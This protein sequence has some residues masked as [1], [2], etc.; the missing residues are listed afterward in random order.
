MRLL[1][2]ENIHSDMVLWLRGR[3]EDVE[4][5]AEAHASASDQ[6]LLERAQAEQRV[7]ITDDRDFGELVY[8]RRLNSHGVILVR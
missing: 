4:Y 2:D 5:V 3:G 1:A 8:H 7:L 6:R